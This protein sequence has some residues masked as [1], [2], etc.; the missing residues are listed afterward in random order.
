[1]IKINILGFLFA[2]LLA[3]NSGQ[4]QQINWYSNSNREYNYEHDILKQDSLKLLY[5]QNK[6]IPDSIAL[7]VLIALAHYPE[8]RDEHIKIKF[9]QGKIAHTSK[10]IWYTLMLPFIKKRYVVTISRKVK[11]GVENTM[12]SRLN[13]NAQ[14]GVLGHEFAHTLYYKYKGK[15]SLIRLA[16]QYSNTD[17]KKQ[18]ENDTDRSAIEHKLGYQLLEWSRAVHETHIEDGRGELYLDERQIKDHM[19]EK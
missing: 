7:Q 9:N 2:F 3:F 4:A 1:M 11:E 12:F 6:K 13:Y 10:P 16:F 14:I 5:G 17:F 15:W 8:L 18:M 19:K